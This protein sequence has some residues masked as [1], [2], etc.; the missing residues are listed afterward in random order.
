[1]IPAPLAPYASL[2]KWGLIAGLLAAVYAYGR[3]DGREAQAKDDAKVIADK[4]RALRDAATAL[5]AAAVRFREID[6]VTRL[7][8]EEAAQWRIA[9]GVADRQAADA[10]QAFDRRLAELAADAARDGATCHES[11]MRICGSPLL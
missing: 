3:G 2:L 10:K 6:T 5:R 4:D 9:A 11:R 7:A 1:M 8:K